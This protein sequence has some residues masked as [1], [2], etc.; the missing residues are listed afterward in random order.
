MVVKT[1]SKGR[2]NTGLNVGASNVERYFPRGVQSVE[3]QLD[4]LQIQ[5]DLTPD[6]WQGQPEIY[7]PR[8]CAWLESKHLSTKPGK[9]PIPLALI[10]EGKNSF[11]LKAVPAST[12]SD[13]KLSLHEHG[14]VVGS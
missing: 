5:C 12:Q 13:T 3:L 14:V 2:G 8:L 1:Q 11:R 10:P 9:G 7:D 4:H 6:F